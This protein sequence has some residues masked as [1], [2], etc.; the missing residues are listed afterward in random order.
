MPTSIKLL[1]FALLL[2]T[3]VHAQ[4]KKPVTAKI[5]TPGMQCDACK[6]RVEDY[7][8]FEDGI[9]KVVAYPKSRYVMV[10]F[11]TDRTNIENI[12]TSIANAGYDAD[13]VTANVDSYKQLPTT[14][15]KPEDGGHPKK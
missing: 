12:K 3:G 11:F 7:L 4:Q 15:K 1:I 10:T 13:D 6:I 5:L 2:E 8:K 9:G 14:C